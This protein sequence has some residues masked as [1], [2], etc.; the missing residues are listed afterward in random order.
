MQNHVRNASAAT[1]P[2]ADI[3]P[4]LSDDETMGRIVVELLEA[5]KNLNSKAL[6]S[7][8]LRRIEVSGSLEEERHY[9]RLIRLV[10]DREPR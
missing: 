9:Q 6:C 3:P 7:K 4:S 10:L 1:L 2:H 8:L 5:G